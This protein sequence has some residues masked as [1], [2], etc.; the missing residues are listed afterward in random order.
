M[1]MKTRPVLA[2][3]HSEQAEAEAEVAVEDADNRI[4]LVRATALPCRVHGTGA[5]T[6]RTPNSVLGT[7]TLT[8][9]RGVRTVEYWLVSR[10][11]GRRR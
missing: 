3:K 5:G 9:V 8:A 2:S 10:Q 4:G 1:V 6:V 7:Q 11:P